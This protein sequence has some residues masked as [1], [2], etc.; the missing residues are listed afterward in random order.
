MKS[1]FIFVRWWKECA[2]KILKH[3]NALGM[4]AAHAPIRTGPTIIILEAMRY[5][6][7]GCKHWTVVKFFVLVNMFDLQ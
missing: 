7:R 3:E 5:I 6:D 2:R 4:A 1:L